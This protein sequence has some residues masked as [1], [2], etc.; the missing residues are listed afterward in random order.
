METMRRIY[1]SEIK[2]RVGE[3]VKIA[4]FVQAIRNQGGITFLIIRDISGVIQVV[5]KKGK[6]KTDKAVATLSLE[7]VVEIAG[8][9]KEE[10]QAPGGVEVAAD[11]LTILSLSAPEL[12]IP[13][14]PKG[15]EET[16]QSI[17]LDWRWIDL[18]KPKNLLIFK[19]WTLMEATFRKYWLTHGYLEIHSPKLI[20]AASESGAEVFEVK[21]F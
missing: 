1:A 3:Q 9:A 15:S 14:V 2:K 17:R 8:L 20:S 21:Y 19:V 16:D 7:S 12:P 10:H 18:R 6:E 5:I 11:T 4:G 13:V